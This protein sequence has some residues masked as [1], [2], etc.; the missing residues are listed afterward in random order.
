MAVM[1]ALALLRGGPSHVRPETISRS[2]ESR[3]TSVRFS[4][5]VRWH[6]HSCLWWDRHSC[7]SLGGSCAASEGAGTPLHSD[8]HHRQECLCHERRRLAL[9]GFATAWTDACATAGAVVGAAAGVSNIL[10]YSSCSSTTT[11]PFI[12]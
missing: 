1:A 4:G 6:R 2:Y 5:P 3:C 10:W 7:L 9:Q 11:V 12:V 8:A